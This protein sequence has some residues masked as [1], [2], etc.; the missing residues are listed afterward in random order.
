[1]VLIFQPN[2]LNLALEIVGKQLHEDSKL[3]LP[4]IPSKVSDYQTSVALMIVIDTIK[5]EE[6]L[7]MAYVP[8]FFESCNFQELRESGRNLLTDFCGY[9]IFNLVFSDLFSQQIATASYF[10]EAN[11]K[12]NW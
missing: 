11:L 3:K 7:Q 10:L 2:H 1:M 6:A 4:K 12:E 8:T 5:L 9:L